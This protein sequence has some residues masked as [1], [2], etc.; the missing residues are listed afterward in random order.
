MKDSFRAGEAQLSSHP[1]TFGVTIE[2]AEI[3]CEQARLA[4]RARR[5]RAARGLFST[6]TAL[7]QRALLQ[8]GVCY[9]SIVR[10][11]KQIELEV[12]TYAELAGSLARP[13]SSAAMPGRSAPR[14][15]SAP[16]PQTPDAAFFRSSASD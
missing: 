15:P 11:L 1:N 16:S 3:C 14:R 4:A 2:E 12:A 8:D 5:F 9:E 10:R 13:L 7:Y 6:A